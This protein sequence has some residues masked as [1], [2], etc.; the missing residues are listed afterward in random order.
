M[1]ARRHRVA[2]IALQAG[3]SRATVDRVLHGRSGVRPQTVAQVRHAIDELDRQQSQVHLSTRSLIVDFVIQ[4]PARFAAA[5]SAA[6]EG[7][8]RGLRPAVLR[9]RHHLRQQSDPA[10][11]AEVLAGIASRGSDGVILKAPD[12]PTVRTAV[13]RLHDKGI[14][15]VTYVTDLP[16]A[17]RV[18]Y[19][20]LDNRAAGATAAHLVAHWAGCRGDILVTVSHGDFEG[21]QARVAGFRATLAEVACRRPVHELSGAHGLDHTML[22]S[23]R[24]AL[25]DL[26]GADTVYSVGGGN[27][28]TLQ[29]FAECGRRPALFVGHDLDA[30]NRELL[31]SGQI[32]VVLHHDLGADLRRACLMLM[33]AAGVVAGSPLS[34]PTQVQVVTRFNEPPALQPLGPTRG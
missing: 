27:R 1:A 17:A 32:D 15:V 16:G 6:L 20:G 30:D 4:A 8:L 24:Q 13:K 11:A 26:P 3:L 25:H 21:E 14:A 28:A 34:L 5:S 22:S 7:E 2:D 29:A 23:V 18:G 9:V 10:A 31:R 19:V 33:Q 12:H